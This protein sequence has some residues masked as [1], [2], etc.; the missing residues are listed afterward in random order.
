VETD[1][2]GHSSGGIVITLIDIVPL[3]F[4]VFEW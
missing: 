3:S 1:V 2:T 4:E